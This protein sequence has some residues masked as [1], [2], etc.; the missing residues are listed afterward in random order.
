[1]SLEEMKQWLEYLRRV[2]NEPKKE[3]TIDIMKLF[4][5][6]CSLSYAIDEIE[7]LKEINNSLKERNNSL[8]EVVNH[9]S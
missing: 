2:L 3:I 8:T 7:K 4:Q 1:M 9:L 5:V 6:E